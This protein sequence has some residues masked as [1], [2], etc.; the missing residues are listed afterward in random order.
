MEWVSSRLWANL[1]CLGAGDGVALVVVLP[2][3]SVGGSF[4]QLVVK[5]DVG[6]VFLQ[7]LGQSYLR[8]CWGWSDP[9][10]GA[11]RGSCPISRSL[12]GWTD[13]IRW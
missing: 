2:G 13:R 11:A 10:G 8:W 9:C 6:W 1:I 7:A 5:I 4:F 12:H 3:D